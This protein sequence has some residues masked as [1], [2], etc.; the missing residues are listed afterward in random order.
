MSDTCLQGKSKKDAK[1]IAAASALEMLLENVPEV[2]FQ[3]PGRG[4][5]QLKVGAV[6]GG[7]VQQQPVAQ[8]CCCLACDSYS[9]LSDL[10]SAYF[11]SHILC[12][13]MCKFKGEGLHMLSHKTNF[14]SDFMPLHCCSLQEAAAEAPRCLLQAAAMA[15]LQALG[16]ALLSHP[17]LGAAAGGHQRLAMAAGAYPPQPA[18]AGPPASWGVAVA[19]RWPQ[20]QPAPMGEPPNPVRSS[21][22][23]PSAGRGGATPLTGR[24]GAAMPSTGRGSGT[25]NTNRNSRP[26]SSSGRGTMPTP[27]SKR[28]RDSST[29]PVPRVRQPAPR[30]VWRPPQQLQYTSPPQLAPPLRQPAPPPQR[31]QQMGMAVGMYSS[32]GGQQGGALPAGSHVHAG[33]APGPA[34]DAR[35][36]GQRC[37]DCCR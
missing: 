2:D 36:S 23:T 11:W 5:K 21:M 4:A 33:A 17:Q 20:L 6:C 1:Q 22:G 7:L 9:G 27:N 16:M 35:C 30:A 8:V 18:S 10:L 28:G 29:V 15:V 12:V 37:C 26:T 3:M 14:L 31:Q 25:P 34:A 19:V 13:R 24:G 32:H